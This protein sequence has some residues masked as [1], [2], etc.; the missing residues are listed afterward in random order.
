MPALPRVTIVCAL[1]SEAAAVVDRFGLSGVGANPFKTYEGSDLRV[2]VS[3]MGAALSAAAVGFMAGDATRADRG[4]WINYGIAGHCTLATGTAI[5]ADKVSSAGADDT[6][7]PSLLFDAPCQTGEVKT[8]A[9]PVTAYPAHACCDMEAA[10]FMPA[11][12]AVAQGE[13]VQV[14][15]IISDN[16]QAGLDGVNRGVVRELMDGGVACLTTLIERLRALAERL[17]VAQHDDALDAILERWHFTYA[18]NKQLHHLHTRFIALS[19][20]VEGFRH[21]I[22]ACA[23]AAQLLRQ[24]EATVDSLPLRVVDAAVS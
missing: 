13:L 21:G 24:I 3:G 5:L 22:D 18:Q 20:D 8:F 6:W 4:I 15:K 2:I 19:A 7:Y 10:G 9:Q 11:A 17:P 14:L 16:A 1:S 23:N 12:M